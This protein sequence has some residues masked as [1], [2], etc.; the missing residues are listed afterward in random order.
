MS[1][2]NRFSARRPKW[3]QPDMVRADGTVNVVLAS[4]YDKVVKE[5]DALKKKLQ[6]ARRKIKDYEAEWN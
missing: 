1:D 4:E 6:A 2:V 3:Y 5:R